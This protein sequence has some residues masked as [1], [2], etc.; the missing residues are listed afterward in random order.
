[1]SNP[2]YLEEDLIE[3]LRNGNTSVFKYI[4]QLY[5]K[6]LFTYAQTIVK[7]TYLAEELVQESFLRIWENR[8]NILI[9]SSLKSYLYQCIHNNCVNFIKKEKTN[10]IRTTAWIDD[11]LLHAE[12]ALMNY[13]ED[14]LDKI[15]SDELE[16][17]LKIH[18]GELPPQCREIFEMSREQH[19]TYPEIA[20]KLG[21]SINT[22][23]TQMFRA[24]DKLKEAQK[25]FIIF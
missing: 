11:V 2:K 23:K 12:M 5:Y 19:F 17:Y 13:S 6:P 1:M 22:V 7:Y 8:S 10:T 25:K 3:G 24:L 15:I 20:T 4:F 18:I 16:H 9:T 14:I 21:V